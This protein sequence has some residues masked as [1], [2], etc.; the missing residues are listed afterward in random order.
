MAVSLQGY[1]ATTVT[2]QVDSSSTVKVGM[3]LTL[4]GNITV[5]PAAAGEEFM[6][7]AT[8]VSTGYAAVQMKGYIQVKVSGSMPAVGF[9]A[10]EADGEGKLKVVAAAAPSS[11]G[12]DDTAQ[13]AAT[14]R[15]VLV[16]D[17]D[18]TNSIA[19]IIL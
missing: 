14:G 18:S 6:G 19:G 15:R 13:T 12:D 5:K 17:V 3:P 10:L 2:F 1:D 9:A 8:A 16:T 4:S 7:I 11:G